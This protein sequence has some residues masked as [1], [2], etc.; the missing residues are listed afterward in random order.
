MMDLLTN[1]KKTIY[2]YGTIVCITAIL[3][4]LK[5]LY[6]NLYVILC[7]FFGLF[8]V[9]FYQS[10]TIIQPRQCSL[11]E[12]INKYKFS[13]GIYSFLKELKDSF[14]RNN[15]SK[16]R[17]SMA[18]SPEVDAILEQ[19]LTY[20][21]RDFIDNWYY[22]INS[23][24]G[25]QESL[26]RMIRRT[27]AAFSFCLSKVD[28]QELFTRDIVDDVASHFRL[29]RKAKE[30]LDIKKEIRYNNL[31]S[32]FFDVELEMEKNYCRDLV[33]TTPQYEVAYFKDVVDILLHL[34]MPAE[35]FRCRPLRFVLRDTLVNRIFIP[36]FDKLSDPDYVNYMIVWLLSEVNIDTDAFILSLETSH[37][38][39]E[40]EAI[41]ES[42][43]EEINGLK[44]K[45]RGREFLD[46]VHQQIASLEF[47]AE[48]IKKRMVVL[49]SH[50][51]LEILNDIEIGEQISSDV[52]QLPITVILTNNVALS[53]FTTFLKKHGGQ[54]YIDCYLAIEGFKVSTE[55]Q[56]R[57]LAGGEVHEEDV[58][59]VVKDSALFL[60]HQFL[61]QEA[62][63]KVILGENVV[64][65]FLARLR[66]DE[67]ADTWF[68]LIEE[69]LIDI[70]NK[71]NQFYPSFKKS[72]EY[73]DLLIELGILLS[74]KDD[75]SM[76]DE[77]DVKSLGSVGSFTSLEFNQPPIGVL[78]KNLIISVVIEHLG[79]GHHDQKSFTLYNM[80]II[81]DNG[82]ESSTSEWNV[83]RRY[84]DF[85]KLNQIIKEKY[86]KLKHI[87]F[88]GKKAFNNFDSMFLEKR[89]AALNVY[90][91]T[92]LETNILEANSGL[93]N[94]IYDFLTQKTYT[95]IKEGLSKKVIS[96]LF[97]PVVTSVKAFGTVVT[98]V[99]DQVIDGVTKVGTGLNRAAS[100]VLNTMGSKGNDLSDYNRV[101][102]DIQNETFSDNIPL[103][104]LLLVFDEVFGLRGRGQW[105]RR[106]LTNLLHQIISATLGGSINKKIIDLVDWL[107]SSEQIVQYLVAFRETMWP[108]GI[109]NTK[110]EMRS[111][112]YSLRT[113][114]FARTQMYASIPDELR[115]FIG[116]N[117][118]VCGIS[119][120][121]DCL[122]N[123]HL[124]R[125]LLYV[126]L[127]R[128]LVKIFPNNRFDKILPQLHSK[129]PRTMTV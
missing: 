85:Y 37:S 126:I 45:D 43:D 33:S 102:A 18:S 4:Y 5:L 21:V 22:H 27:I 69:K 80:K 110:Q 2:V 64:N 84:S 58:I 128:L 93:D 115:I 113:R 112:S 107:T 32:L 76:I 94:I 88:P 36:C 16:E 109:L 92:I 91:N 60:Y 103:Q 12:L 29:F 101:A 3:F 11:E 73:I 100:Q 90:I 117:V 81:K 13:P 23:D 39:P 114:L 52:V 14:E 59:K 106:Q 116:T 123:R 26:K 24:S 34:L 30:R 28:W 41:L 74:S 86:P 87:A 44:S 31:E 129:S 35:D 9:I 54:N 104:V 25:F 120:I 82:P 17:H 20:F 71:D 50:P 95:G 119:N 70:L 127:E 111:L 57:A 55:Q 65:K 98:S 49:T 19:L 8:Y 68:E 62:K 125:R 1:N 105:F 42:I 77:E 6:I 48:T 51:N 83:I 61:S 79:I 124:N 121:S 66:N 38:V 118:A 75:E 53:Y 99:P 63:T 67:P 47:A 15:H 56:F 78:K 97:N 89:S 122:Q 46:I 96:N 7:F 10:N 108:N 40:L 72:N